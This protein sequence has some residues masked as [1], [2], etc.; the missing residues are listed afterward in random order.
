LVIV[1]EASM[2]SLELMK[3]LLSA[4]RDDTR[5][6]LLGDK[7]QLQSVEAGAVFADIIDAL[8]T[9]DSATAM[10]ELQGNRRNSPGI[11]ALAQA[12]LDGDATAVRG[13]VAK[14]PEITFI[15]A[16]PA[17]LGHR[18][19]SVIRE[20]RLQQAT[21]ITRAA[22]SGDA[23]TA[24]AHLSDFRLLCAHQDGPAGVHRWS[25]QTETFLTRRLA[26]SGSTT[27]YPGRTV[28]LGR[29]LAEL[30]L[31]NGD[32]GVILGQAT[33]PQVCFDTVPDP[34][35]YPLAALD[36]L[37]PLYTMT[38]H[39][40]QGSEYDRVAIILPDASSPLLSRQLL[41]TAVTR[42][43]NE[44]TIVGTRAALLKAVSTPAL[45]ASGLSAQLL[46]AAE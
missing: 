16:D 5:L 31:N 12:I 35:Q 38:I 3:T 15:N 7:N 27:W 4:L 39:K 13:T 36:N 30:G 23:A 46:A 28:L 19:L 32:Q 18:D 41:Y 43:R 26:P 6:V 17:D 42:A 10:V 1:D 45:R 40:S 11:A 8:G 25:D 14:A 24:L 9:T 2:V 20:P 33:S 44:L 29:N 22:A 21:A 34:R 37:Q